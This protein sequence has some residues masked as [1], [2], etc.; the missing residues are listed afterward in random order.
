MSC[1]IEQVRVN[2]S[3]ETVIKSLY[4]YRTWSWGTQTPRCCHAP[5]T[6]TASQGAPFPAPVRTTRV[7]REPPVWITGASTSVS[8]LKVSQ[9]V[10]ILVHQNFCR[11]NQVYI[12]YLILCNI[13][14]VDL[15][16]SHCFV[17]FFGKRKVHILIVKTVERSRF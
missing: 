17:L 1:H 8:V 16:K 10:I 13:F 15:V 9:G 5:P 12:R 11:Q 2:Q 7:P 3:K 4:P 14:V 6:A